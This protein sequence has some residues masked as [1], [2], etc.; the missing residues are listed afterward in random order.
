MEERSIEQPSVDAHGIRPPDA[1]GIEVRESVAGALVLA[2]IG[3]FDLA[4]AAALRE[5]LD[6]AKETADRGVVLDLTEVT[7]VDSAG[8][9]ELLRAHGALVGEGK[10]L[11]LT[12]LQP[13]VVRLFELTGA[14]DVLVTAPTLQ[15][16][17]TLLAGQP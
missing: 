17:L 4:A 12:G 15:R 10:A 8:L 11:V 13:A 7:F 16:G 14:T 1:Y 6:A 2:L 5:Q 3:E 9:R